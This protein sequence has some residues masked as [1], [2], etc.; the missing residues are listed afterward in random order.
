MKK[1][2]L[3]LT[4]LFSL[5]LIIAGINHFIHPGVYASLI[6]GW[7]PLT[8]TN[9]VTGMIETAL[10]AGLL[11][12]P[13]RRMA[14][15]GTILLMVFFLP[16]HVYDVFRLH[17]AIGSTK[18]ALIRLPLQFLLIYWAWFLVPRAK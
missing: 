14:A 8:A 3:T 2:R 18:L 1:L 12:T 9:Y 10:G 4:F 13:S 17:P 7:L 6:P 11:F 5:L 16:F 15:I